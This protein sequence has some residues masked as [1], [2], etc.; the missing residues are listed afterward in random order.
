MTSYLQH[1][2]G[3][4]TVSTLNLIPNPEDDGREV[5]CRAFLQPKSEK[6]RVVVP[7][8]DAMRM[9]VLCKLIY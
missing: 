5:V 1:E 7:V 4:L 8:Q 2:N 6:R 3:N 9:S